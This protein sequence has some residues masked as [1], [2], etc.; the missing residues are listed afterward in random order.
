MNNVN[1]NNIDK[2]FLEECNTERAEHEKE[3]YSEFNRHEIYEIKKYI[4]EKPLGI[5]TAIANAMNSGK[6]LFVAP[7]GSGKSFSFIN[8]LKKIK[9]KALFILP[10]ASNVEQAMHEY[11]IAGAYDKIPAKQALEGNN[12]AVMT[13]DKTEQLIDIDLSEY[14]I[15]VDE[16]HQTYTDAY[17]G[18]AIKNL[19]NIMSKCKGRIDITATPT[20]L[21]FEI[22]DY[23]IEYT[24]T[25]KTEYNV[26]LYNDFDNKNFT[27]IIN[28]I[29]KSKNSAM[30]MNDI[31]TLEF[32]RD[33]VDKNA[34]VV[35]ADG[36]EENELYNR[37][38]KNSDMKGYE[39]L[40]NTTTILAGVN[41]KNKNIT[42][43]II[44]NIKDVG[45]IKQYVARFRNLKKA[46]IHI[47]NKY[48][49]E[50]NIY[51][52]EWLV[53]KN[54]EKATILKDAYNKVSKHMLQ[55]ETVGINATPIRMDSNVYY[56]TKDN[57]Y[58]V[59]KLYI[60]SQ[61]YSNYY[62][63]RTIQSFKVLLEEYFENIEIVDTKEIGTNEKEL[64][65]YKKVA[66]EIKDATRE[67][68]K[69]HKEILVGYR[70]IK[71]NSKSFSLM[72]YHNDMKLSSEGC[73]KAYKE[74]DIHNLV[75]KSK[76][77]SMLELYSNYVLENKFSL[78]LAWKLA[79][80]ANKKRGVVFNKIN[81]LIYRELKEEYPAF[82]NDEL[83]QVTVFNYIDKLFGIGTS[84]K[85]LHLQ[86]LSNDLRLILGENWNLNTK[87]LGIVL[88]GIFIIEKKK[89]SNWHEI[90]T[91]FFYKNINPISC[92][93]EKK[94]IQLNNIKRY[95]TVDDIKKDLEL[96]AKDKS[97]EN[98]IKYTKDRMLNSL[99][100][101]EKLL[102][103]KGF[104]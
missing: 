64:K 99:D 41:I 8:T 92:Q 6:T 79:N 97:L 5:R 103:L 87:K 76:S 19:N 59:D 16:I 1:K 33:S 11:N 62:N 100:E 26:K 75:K 27:E 17:R 96:D 81:T 72:Q 53:N 14:I 90:E 78:E 57:C 91:M 43:I 93:S 73:L 44:V 74:Y 23:I 69:E 70:Q 22:Y 88:N 21:E 83:I 28:I 29:N 40:L 56:C 42:D 20:K 65:E 49:E 4:D 3:N 98:A 51:K 52:I 25:Q 24:Q 68:L 34:N 86:E 37:I 102:L 63:T 45:A 39:T 9:I 10:N 47:F 94:R 18:K 48:E 82:L 35:Y 31:S 30:L 32:I 77:N 7:T 89:Y 60:K 58:K 15:V 67:I 66:K 95:V 80:T 104:M 38:V 12:L 71:S 13:W 54:I 84:Y 50:C 46:N 85:E 61:V 2:L 101:D 55:F 36:K